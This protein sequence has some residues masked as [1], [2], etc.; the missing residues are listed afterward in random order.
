MRRRDA[1]ILNVVEQYGTRALE[2][3]GIYKIGIHGLDARHATIG[4]VLADGGFEVA[5]GLVA[6]G[7]RCDMLIFAGPR[8]AT[9][10]VRRELERI[11]EG[12]VVVD[13]MEGAPS[14]LSRRLVR[15]SVTVLRSGTSVFVSGS[16]AEAVGLVGDVFQAA[17][18]VV[19]PRDPLAVSYGRYVP[20]QVGS[21]G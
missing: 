21:A 13:A 20:P 19:I 2:A 15:V 18:C 7:P 11:D 14:V 1:L 4:R 17:G 3:S 10:E 5:S 8:R 16:D 9:A 12:A 6:D